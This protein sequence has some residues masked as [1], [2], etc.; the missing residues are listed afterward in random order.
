[1]ATR[2][3]EDLPDSGESFPHVAI[4]DLSSLLAL[5]GQ[6]RKYGVDLSDDIL[7]VLLSVPTVLIENSGSLFLG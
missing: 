6:R 1:M 5:G 2:V 3:V 7:S 4:V